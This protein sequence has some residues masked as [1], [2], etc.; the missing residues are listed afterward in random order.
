MKITRETD[1]ALRA[2]RAIAE[3]PERVISARDIAQAENIPVNF[4]FKILKMLAGAG[5]VK[6]HRGCGGGYELVKPLEE[7]YIG[8]MI[9]LFEDGIH[10]N[11]CTQRENACV[12]QPDCR[13][14]HEFQR[15]EE[16]LAREFSRYSLAELL[17]GPQQ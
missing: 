6:I 7:I 10:L 15:V 1:Y 17:A 4:L 12:N 16:I 9:E 5:I 14:H 8:D 11:L 13:L 2:V 3:M